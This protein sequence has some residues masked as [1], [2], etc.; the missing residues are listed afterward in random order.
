MLLLTLIGLAQLALLV[1]IL[2]VVADQS[3]QSEDK[4]VDASERIR[5]MQRQTIEAM[6]SAAAA[7]DVIDGQA[8]PYPR[9]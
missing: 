4:A 5:A 3:S 8:R 6:F 7:D 2:A 9:S 1:M